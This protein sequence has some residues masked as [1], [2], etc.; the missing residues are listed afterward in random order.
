MDL[1]LLWHIE[2]FSLGFPDS[3][4]PRILVVNWYFLGGLSNKKL[5][6]F[7]FFFCFSFTVNWWFAGFGSLV[8]RLDPQT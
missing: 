8:F 1:D 6:N 5:S 7:L 2:V 4:C 3:K